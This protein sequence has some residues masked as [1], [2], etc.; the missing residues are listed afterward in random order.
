M[1]QGL[2]NISL[3][4]E[5]V[6]SRPTPVT[7]D[8]FEIEAATPA[9]LSSYCASQY[10][11]LGIPEIDWVNYKGNCCNEC[12][13]KFSAIYN[14]VDVNIGDSV[15]ASLISSGLT[16]YVMLELCNVFSFDTFRQHD[17]NLMPVSKILMELIVGGYQITL[18][19]TMFLLQ[20][21]LF[22]LGSDE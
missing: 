10:T 13:N 3:F 7:G 1:A 17:F 11:D 22:G 20:K 9:P 2:I 16:I 5:N 8:E 18:P 15:G 14:T 12:I 21:V 6:A 19:K 4:Q